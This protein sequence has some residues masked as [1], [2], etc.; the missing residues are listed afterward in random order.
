[1]AKTGAAF[2]PIDPNYPTGRIE[3][4]LTD[5][6]AEVGVTVGSVLTQ[7][8]DGID[9]VVV[10]DLDEALGAEPISDVDRLRPLRPEHPAYLIYTSGSTGTPKGVVVTQAGIASFSDEQR[11]RYRVTSSS[12]TL[13]LASPS[14]DASVLEL[15]LAVGGA[16]TMVVAE[17]TVYAGAE[18][19]ALLRREQVT[20]IFITPSALASVD[21]T[22]LDTL[23]VVVAGGEACPPDLVR[24]WVQPISGN[25]TREFYNG[26]GP[27]ET[28]IMTNISDP[29]ALDG[30]VTIGGPIRGITE[31]VLSGRLS[32]VPDRAVGELY[33]TGAQVARGYHERPALTAA[34]FVPNPFDPHG[35]RLY[36]TGDLVRRT[37]DGGLEYLGRNDFQVKIRGLRIELGEIDAT[38]AAHES[39]G[40]AATIGHRN[41]SGTESLV[42]YVVAAQ[43][44]T[45]D[46]AVLAEYAA[47]RLPSYMVPV[48][49]MV[50]DGI[51]LTPVGKLD[52]RALPDPVFTDNTVFRAPQTPIECTIAE[53]FADVLGIER[54]GLDD[55]FFALG[56][57]S[58]MSIQLVARARAAGLVFSAR[59]VFDHK[60]VAG[61]AR[62]AVDG[63]G[64]AIPV[65]VELP[66]GGVGSMPL[67]PIMRWM[68]EGAASGVG[69]FSQA[70]LLG[71]PAGIDRRVLA[72]TVQAVLDRHD[73]LRARLRRVADG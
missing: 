65:P 73:M 64:A 71:L 7:L 2:V 15:L 51:P 58:I 34:R 36:R 39:V 60:T 8:P 56:G 59:D 72:G 13:H 52:R 63:G 4:M 62:V 10:D 43:D 48:S 18:L 17:P 24:R 12:R 38:L 45:I 44:H 40:F 20:H 66:G 27:T 22:G 29:L 42:S 32:L 57:D 31:Y 54:V 3:H 21:P 16:A 55:S 30:P 23:R 28:T 33:I 35:D 69:R 61:L 19:A 9:W 26:Y 46:T 47:G 11:Q 70:M 53:S 25:R 5:S 67:T 41:G 14:F 68:L 1:I 37:V 49:I 6:G 50:L